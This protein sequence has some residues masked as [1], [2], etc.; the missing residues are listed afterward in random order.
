MAKAFEIVLKVVALLPV[1]VEIVGSIEDARKPDSPGGSKL[2]PTELAQLIV[3][4]GAKFVK[5]LSEVF[6]HTA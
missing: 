1:I 6:G 2:T 3:D 5:K 4:G